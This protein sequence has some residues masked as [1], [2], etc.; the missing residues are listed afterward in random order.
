MSDI[1]LPR[2]KFLVGAASLLAAPAVIRVAKLMPVRV[3]KERC[4]FYTVTSHYHWS[5]SKPMFLCN[6]PSN[7]Y[8]TPTEFDRYIKNE[9]DSGAY[10]IDWTRHGEGGISVQISAPMRWESFKGS[11]NLET[12]RKAEIVG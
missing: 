12:C 8:V 3:W 9:W 2:R 6:N 10:A 5:N 1:I 7:L 4:D 11:F